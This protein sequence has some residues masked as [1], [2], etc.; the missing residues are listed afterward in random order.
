LPTPIDEIIKKR[1]QFPWHIA[2]AVSAFAVNPVAPFS[3]PQLPLDKETLTR[4]EDFGRRIETHASDVK[5][6]QR[7][8]H[9]PILMAPKP[10]HSETPTYTQ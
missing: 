10:H 5:R 1:N 9:I 4:L 6:F 2:D 7:W 3:M 8:R